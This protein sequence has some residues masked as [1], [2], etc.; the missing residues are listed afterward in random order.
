MAKRYMNIHTG[1]TLTLRK[2]CVDNRAKPP[3]N[4]YVMSDRS[5]WNEALFR[6]QWRYVDEVSEQEEERASMSQIKAKRY[7][8][9]CIITDHHNNDKPLTR[10][11]IIERIE[12]ADLRMAGLTIKLEKETMRE[13]GEDAI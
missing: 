5:A 9:S 12:G 3:V 7:R 6:G 13:V 8:V 2:V 1:E 10:K 4:V 11:E